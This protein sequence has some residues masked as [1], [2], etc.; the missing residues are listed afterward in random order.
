MRRRGLGRRLIAANVE[1]ALDR[2]FDHLLLWV[3]EGN[4]P[5]VALY[6]AYGFAF[7]GDSRAHPT[8]E[9]YR[10]L[11]MRLAIR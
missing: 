8:Y 6:L 1:W 7:T 5:A 4:E 11:E 3:T 10:E 2:G 9:G